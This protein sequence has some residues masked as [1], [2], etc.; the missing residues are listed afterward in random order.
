VDTQ[1]WLWGL[2]VTPANVQDKT[3]ARRLAAQVA[4]LAPRLT[5]VWADGGFA[6]E[7]LADDLAAYGWTLEVVQ[8]TAALRGFAVLPKRWIVERSFGWWTQQRRLRI[9]Y[10]ERMEVSATYVYLAM[11]GL[12][13][14]RLV[15]TS[16]S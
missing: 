3:G 11:I 12:M 4:P 6:S 8:P 15:H 7:A 1:G 2:L 13:T 14:R 9:D 10:E 5:H 16:T